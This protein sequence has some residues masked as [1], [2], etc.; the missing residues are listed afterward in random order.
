MASV[1]KRLRQW[2]V[3]PPFAGSIPVVRPFCAEFIV[4]NSK[5]L[6]NDAQ[7]LKKGGNHRRLLFLVSE[8][9]LVD[10]AN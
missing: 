3:I 9:A 1:A 8:W 4:H 10:W 6:K 5:M 2:I 7:K